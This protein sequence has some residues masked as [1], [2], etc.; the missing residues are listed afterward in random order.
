M[1]LKLL[2][3]DFERD[4]AAKEDTRIYI[5]YCYWLGKMYNYYLGT[6]KTDI[7]RYL[8]VTITEIGENRVEIPVSKYNKKGEDIYLYIRYD[9]KELLDKPYLEVF[10]ILLDIFHNRIM[11]YAAANNLDG[12]VFQDAY[13]RI[14][15]NNFVFEENHL[16]PVSNNI[17]TAQM[18]FE[19]DFID[20]EHITDHVFVEIYKEKQLINKIV[21]LR[22]ASYVFGDGYLDKDMEWIDDTHIKINLE[23][24]F[25][26]PSYYWIISIDGTIEFESTHKD[27]DSEIFHIG[28]AYYKG[29]MVEKNKAKGYT[30]IKRAAEMGNYYAEQWLRRYKEDSEPPF[31]VPPKN[32]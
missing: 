9:H 7:L 5:D 32:Y 11:E 1:E 2:A 23:W 6:I 20:A 4:K 30:M 3:F 19:F 13:N 12:E 16:N 31:W 21:F 25:F 26:P 14:I 27:D 18:R 15:R 29:V 22:S 24:K 17:Y 10:R 8:K 28:I